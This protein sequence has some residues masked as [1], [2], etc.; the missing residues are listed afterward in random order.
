MN[1]ISPAIVE[2]QSKAPP[3]IRNVIKFLRSS[4][5]GIKVRV[6]ALNGGRTDY[7]KGKHAMKALQSPAYAKVKNVP[8]VESEEDALKLL[9]SAMPFA[10]FLRVDRGQPTGSA[11]NSP[12]ALQIN[13]MQLFQQ[14]DYYAWFYE[15]SQWMTTVGGFAML[16]VMLAGVM[17]PL[18]PPIMRL[19]VW[20]ISIGVLGLIGL[21]FAIAVVRLIFYIITIIVASP[22]IWI[23]PK[24]FADVGFVESF[25]PLWEWDM[26]KKKKG[27]KA[28]KSE[29]R[30]KGEIE[31]VSS[32]VDVRSVSP[33]SGSSRPESRQAR[34]EEV[35]EDS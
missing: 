17:F 14:P 8:K 12:K 2:Q 28:V 26:P 13:Q 20:Y 33:D 22:G 23:F 11:A 7:F 3:E 15:P 35:Q 16:G 9:A 19:G 5:S 34:I 18:W 21:F 1:N 6:G 32:Q 24:L 31:G 27:K 10:Y 4:K 29:K 30:T 25:I